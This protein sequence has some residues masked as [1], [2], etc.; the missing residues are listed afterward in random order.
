MRPWAVPIALVLPL[1]LSLAQGCGIVAPPA[2][3]N[4]CAPRR[5]WAP[6]PPSLRRRATFPSGS[7]LI[8]ASG[9]E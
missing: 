7:S 1:L 6:L 8:E 4:A 5:A 2:R 9:D 3:L